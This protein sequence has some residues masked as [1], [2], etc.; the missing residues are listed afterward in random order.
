MALKLRITGLVQ[1]VGYRE[2]MRREAALLG[3]R[4]WVRNCRDGSVEALIEGPPDAV[5]SLID[6]AW[7][8]PRAARVAGVRTVGVEPDETLERFEIR[9]S[10]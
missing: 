10:D 5:R 6:W 7:R 2:T 9:P 1:G 4:G 3:I 8:G